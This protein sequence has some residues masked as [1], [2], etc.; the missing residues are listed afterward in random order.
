MNLTVEQ[1]EL[2]KKLDHIHVS[3]RDYTLM[4]LNSTSNNC[5]L[6]D[7]WQEKL[8]A[9]YAHWHVK[10][11]SISEVNLCGMEIMSELPDQLCQLVVDDWYSKEGSDSWYKAGRLSGSKR[12]KV[13][14]GGYPQESLSNEAYLVLQWIIQHKDEPVPVEWLENMRQKGVEVPEESLSSATM[15]DLIDLSPMIS[16]MWK[17]AAAMDWNCIS[18]DEVLTYLLERPLD[19][20][21]HGA[22]MLAAF[23]VLMNGIPSK[24]YAKWWKSDRVDGLPANCDEAVL[25]SVKEQFGIAG[26][27][28]NDLESRWDALC[29]GL[30][31]YQSKLSFDEHAKQFLQWCKNGMLKEDVSYS[32]CWKKIAICILKNDVTM[33]YCGFAPTLRERQA[34]EEA[35]AAFSTKQSEREQAQ[36]NAQ[37]MAEE[38]EKRNAMKAAR[39]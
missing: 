6:R 24:Q 26:N 28:E 37:A 22:W 15:K 27:H 8:L 11:G 2:V 10:E 7:I 23:D 38:I 34:R 14:I 33:K 3:W 29:A 21:K 31:A 30:K 4:L 13:C 17:L 1:L 12:M 9:S 35:M 18:Q 32:P 36:K 16:R 5:G 39:A 20:T 25:E 19:D